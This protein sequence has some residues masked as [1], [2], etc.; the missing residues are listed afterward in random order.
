MIARGERAVLLLEDALIPS[1]R[2]SAL[3]LKDTYGMCDRFTMDQMTHTLGLA[4]QRERIHAYMAGVSRNIP[5]ELTE[6]HFRY[7]HKARKTLPDVVGGLIMPGEG[8]VRIPV[9]TRFYTLSDR[10]N[11]G[12][13]R[14][15]K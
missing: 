8:R 4:D 1:A 7:L 12:D 10:D 14:T 5:P 3:W 13:K 2:K 15:Y 6:P 9:R 11:R